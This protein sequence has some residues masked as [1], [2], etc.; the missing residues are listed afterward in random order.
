[1]YFEGWENPKLKFINTIDQIYP[2]VFNADPDAVPDW[3]LYEKVSKGQNCSAPF[4]WFQPEEQ[5]RKTAISS[6]PG[7]GNTWARHLLHMSTGYWTGNRRKSNHL[8]QAGWRA[9]D[10][11]CRDRTTVAQKSHI[12]SKNKGTERSVSNQKSLIL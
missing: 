11:D 2:S 7:S 6:F 4:R 8:K 9:E 12:L 10:N 3:K 5:R 1:M